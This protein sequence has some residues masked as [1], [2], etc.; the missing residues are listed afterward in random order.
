[1]KRLLLLILLVIAGCGPGAVEQA[2]A[3]TERQISAL[4]AA[5]ATVESMTGD[6]STAEE[7]KQKLPE[8][9]AAIDAYAAAR[10]EMPELTPGEVAEVQARFAG[11]LTAVNERYTRVTGR[12]ITRPD[13]A[14]VLLDDLNRL[15]AMLGP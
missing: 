12:L 1:M 14:V 6:G 11:R 13:I 7:A 9:R 15:N 4:E 8:L 3:V 2:S 10:E 5:L